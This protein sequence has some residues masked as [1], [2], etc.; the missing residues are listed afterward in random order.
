MGRHRHTIV[1]GISDTEFESQRSQ[2][3]R[4][5]R[6]KYIIPWKRLQQW[7]FLKYGLKPE[8]FIDMLFKQNG[9][10]GICNNFFWKTPQVDHAHN[11]TKNARGLLC[12]RCNTA[13]GFIENSKLCIQAKRYLRKT[14]KYL[15][16]R[17]KCDT[18]VP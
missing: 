15:T 5:Y 7:R 1:M 17:L 4:F 10:C 11:G 8:Q 13:L 6:E 12:N 9:R 2:K 16:N 18:I 3:Q 14:K